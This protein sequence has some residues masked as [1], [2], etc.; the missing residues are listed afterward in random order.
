MRVADFSGRRGGRHGANCVPA[1]GRAPPP[2][3]PREPEIPF[4][5]SPSPSLASAVTSVS[6][7]AL[8]HR[9]QA[10]RNGAHC[11]T[12]E[13]EKTGGGENSAVAWDVPAA[14]RLFPFLSRVRCTIPQDAPASSG[15]SCSPGHVDTLCNTSEGNPMAFI[16]F[17]IVAIKAFVILAE[18]NHE[19]WI[20]IY[21]DQQVPQRVIHW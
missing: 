21:H 2:P 17:L 1:V 19:I 11:R 10:K 7:V 3:S 12:G 13:G 14:A 4:G 5:R 8:R 16:F 9:N 20:R 15:T 18:K 6:A